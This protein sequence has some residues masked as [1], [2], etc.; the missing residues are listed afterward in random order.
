[1]DNGNNYR[2]GMVGLVNIQDLFIYGLIILNV[3][4][5]V[6]VMIQDSRIYDLTRANERLTKRIRNE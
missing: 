1:M 5:C 3:A 2:P 6:W 4:L